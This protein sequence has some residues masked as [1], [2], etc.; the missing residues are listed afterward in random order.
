MIIFPKA[1]INLGLRITGKRP[2]GYH[3]IETLLYPIPLSDAL[4]LVVSSDS[5]KKDILTVT[6]INIGGDPEDNLVMKTLRTLRERHSLPWLRIHLHKVIPAGAGLGGGSSDAVCLL[7]IM[8][9]CF[10]LSFDEKVLK[11]IALELGSDCP[12]FINGIP[13]LATGRGEILS[14]VRPFLDG[15]YILLLNPGTGI[16]TREAYQNCWPKKPSSS[17]L[18]LIDRPIIEWK[19]KILNDFESFAINKYPLIGEIKNILYDAGALFSSMSG[20][21]TSVYGIFPEKPEIP[22]RLKDFVIFEGYL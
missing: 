11:T 17:L 18:Q 12:F 10:G 2:D 19:E 7:K 22:D 16:S 1:K 8:N 13:S 20:S 6:G 21:G 4:E 9:K 5:I 14:P 3:D 15:L